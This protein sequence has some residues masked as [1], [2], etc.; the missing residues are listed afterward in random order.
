MQED[1]GM[2]RQ[3][4]LLIA[5]NVLVQPVLC[6]HEPLPTQPAWQTPELVRTEKSPT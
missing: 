4:M 1:A 3:L 5:R 6:E 2:M